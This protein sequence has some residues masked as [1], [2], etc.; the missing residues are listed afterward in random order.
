VLILPALQERGNIPSNAPLFT[1]ERAESDSY[2]RARASQKYM[3]G[4]LCCHRCVLVPGMP[5]SFQCNKFHLIFR[6]Q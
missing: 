3:R 1:R 6:L 5:F 4:W 2:R